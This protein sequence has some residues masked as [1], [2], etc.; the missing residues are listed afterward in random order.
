[1]NPPIDL[2]AYFA[3][4]GYRGPHTA[5]LETLRSLHR[6]HPQQIPFE[7]LGP[8][9]REPVLLTPE[10]IQAKLVGAGR[11]GYCFEHNHLLKWALEALGFEVTG[12]AARVVWGR[13]PADTLPPRS[14]MVLRVR[15]EDGDETGDFIADVGF[16]G[17]T[18]TAP[19]RLQADIEQATPHEPFRLRAEGDVFVMEAE[20][21]DVWTPL[22]RLDLVPQEPADYVAMNWYSATH[23]ESRFVRQLV[24]ARSEPGR[25]YT[26]MDRELGIHSLETGSDKRPLTTP[27]Q[28]R[29]ALGFTMNI[30]L[31]DSPALNAVLTRIAEGE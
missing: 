3:R 16:G 13:D 11:G 7:N 31:P 15:V 1:M 8:L 5:S 9:L 24:V 4:I 25:R 10:A 28:L 21:R 26:L 20:I 17:L 19:L 14:H 29:E 22:Y 30:R 23:P 2:A 18:L 6:L 27:G 12:L